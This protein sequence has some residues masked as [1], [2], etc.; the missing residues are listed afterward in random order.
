MHG[1]EIEFVFG[2]PFNASLG[3]TDEE[4]E[5]SMRMMETWTTFGRTGWV[6]CDDGGVQNSDV[7]IDFETS[8]PPIPG[9]KLIL[10]SMSVC[11]EIFVWQFQ[12][13]PPKYR[14]TSKSVSGLLSSAH[15]AHNVLLNLN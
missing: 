1:Y 6:E 15:R 9:P 4:R 12:F 11:D 3:Y 2:R 5:M 13:E 7:Q 10:M 14:E 8:T